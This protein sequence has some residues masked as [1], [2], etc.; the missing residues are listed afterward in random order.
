LTAQKTNAN[1][2]TDTPSAY[3]LSDGVDHA[4]DLMPG[5]HRLARVGAQALNGEHIAVSHTATLHAKPHMTGLRPEQLTLN[6]LKLPLT[7]Y[8]KSPIR[9]HAKPPLVVVASCNVVAP[10]TNRGHQHCVRQSFRA[11]S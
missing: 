1:A 6:Q 4:D 2:V 8:L 10:T 3:L 9:R 7:G 5:D 11:G